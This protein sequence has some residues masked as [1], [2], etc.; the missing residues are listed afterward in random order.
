[1]QIIE[2]LPSIWAKRLLFLSVFLCVLCVSVVNR[3]SS[4]YVYSYEIR[5]TETIAR[6]IPASW[7]R[8]TLSFRKII[9]STRVTTG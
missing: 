4:F 3:F 2:I 8:F 1:M 6:I 5:T 7:T 9:A